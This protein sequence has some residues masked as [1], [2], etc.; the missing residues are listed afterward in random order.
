MDLIIKADTHNF[1]GLIIFDF[2]TMILYHYHQEKI[3]SANTNND[4]EN[5]LIKILKYDPSK[6]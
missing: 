5:I 6:K 2:I 1:A 4:F 3:V